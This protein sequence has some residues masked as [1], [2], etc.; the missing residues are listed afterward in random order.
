MQ[1]GLTSIVVPS[2]IASGGIIIS[3]FPGKRIIPRPPPPENLPSLIVSP[4]Q[5]TPSIFGG[6]IST[7]TWTRGHAA[8]WYLLCSCDFDRWGYI[9]WG[10][11][12]IS[13]AASLLQSD[14]PF[15][16]FCVFNQFWTVVSDGSRGELSSSWLACL[17]TRSP[18]VTVLSAKMLSSVFSPNIFDQ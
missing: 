14:W 8:L 7:S 15:N 4:L 13:V 5:N 3:L 18:V 9:I 6:V 17:A 16:D 11:L 2:G 12:S 1:N 10:L